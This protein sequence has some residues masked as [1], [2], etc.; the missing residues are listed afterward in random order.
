MNLDKLLQE[1]GLAATF[2]PPQPV[3]LRR[4]PLRERPDDIEALPNSC[5]ASLRSPFPPEAIEFAS[6]F[7]LAGQRP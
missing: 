6:A 7:T 5:A 1:G 3:Q 4:P 2:P